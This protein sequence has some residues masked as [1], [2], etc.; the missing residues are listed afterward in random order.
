MKLQCS[1]LVGDHH[2]G[3]EKMAKMRGFQSHDHFAAEYIK[4][5]NAVI[6]EHNAVVFLGDC[7]MNREAL[8]ILGKLN[9]QI[10]LVLGNHDNLTQ[11]E[12]AQYCK[13]YPM[14]VSYQRKVILSHIPV[15]TSFFG[16][17]KDWLNIHGHM[18]TYEVET[19]FGNKDTRYLSTCIEKIGLEPIHFSELV[20]RA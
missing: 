16:F 17:K 18:H 5:H 12:Y 2:F 20:K 1:Y 14:I 6:Q 7:V 8:P 15:H 10:H 3:S 4:A 13:T 11:K 9:G 19:V